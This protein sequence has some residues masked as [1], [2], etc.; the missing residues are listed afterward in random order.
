MVLLLYFAVKNM[1]VLDLKLDLYW[2][3]IETRKSGSS[4]LS[5]FFRAIK[6]VYLSELN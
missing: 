1:T 5:I 6:S 2:Y 3:A 4:V